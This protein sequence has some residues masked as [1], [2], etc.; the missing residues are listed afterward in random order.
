MQPS[1]RADIVTR[2]TYNRPL[3]DSGEVFEDWFETIDRVIAHQKWLWE[4][5]LTHKILR[6]MPLHDVTEDMLEWVSLD[7]EQLYELEILRDIM[8]KREA[9][10]SGR[11]LWLGGTDVSKKRE[12]SQFNC[13][14]TKIETVYDVVDVFWLLLQGC[15]V[16]FTPVKG[17]LTGFRKPIPEI[18]V[19][20]SERTEKGGHEENEE[21]FRDGIW[22]IRVG[23]SAES[24]AKSVGK[25]LAGKY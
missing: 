3:D 7:D 25:L 16:G 17:T 6:D 12:A 21:S 22:T 23:D 4:R 13:A 14:H 11:T 1:T 5:A 20:R 15:G 2:R 18:E 10:P 9:L 8:L 19:I 24:W